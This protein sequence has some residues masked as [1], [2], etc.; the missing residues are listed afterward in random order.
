MP[1]VEMEIKTVCNSCDGSGLY[2]GLAEDINEA[3]VCI[4]CDGKGWQLITYKLFQKRKK[5]SNVNKIRVSQGKFIAAG[6][7]GIGMSM[8]Y[9]EFENKYPE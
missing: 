3:V 4:D 9:S 8:T 5:L 2:Q 6:V 7:G 1:I